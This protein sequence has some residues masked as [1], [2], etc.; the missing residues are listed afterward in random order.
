MQ[1]KAR[2]KIEFRSQCPISSAL[3][4]VGDKWSLLIIRDLMFFQKRTFSE[5]AKSDEK[6]ASNILTD[7]LGRMEEAGIV[8][9][10]R[11]P[12]NKKAFIYILTE[13]GVD[14][15]PVIVEYILW[16]D[17]YLHDHIADEARQFAEL[18]GK[19]KA[20]VIMET[21]SKLVQTLK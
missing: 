18:L 17:K 2:K 20:A 11:L 19:N 1:A 16:S 14:F 4:I 9:K 13:K 10:S 15:L 6:I 3:D 8:T 21:R 7:R 5:L 12:D